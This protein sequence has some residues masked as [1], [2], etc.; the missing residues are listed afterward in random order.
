MSRLE[1]QAVSF[2]W[3]GR[4]ELLSEVSLFL[5][6]GRIIAILGANGAGK[7]SLLSVL[8]GRLRP[9]RGRVLVEGTPLS[10]LSPREIARRIAFLPQI[11]R[12]PFNYPVLDFVLLGRAPHIPPLSL[13]G[14]EDYRAARSA[15]EEVG[16]AGLGERGAATLSGGEF[17][18]VRIARCLAQEAEI[19]LL[20]EPSVLLDPAHAAS[21]A[22]QLSALAKSGKSV[23]I[24]THDIGLAYSVADT[25]ILLHEGAVLDSGPAER[26]FDLGTLRKAF[27]AEFAQISLP[28]A[29]SP[30][31]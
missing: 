9:N 28:S 5:G 29:Y 10:S 8:A 30:R 20:D 1:A 27:G 15:L 22:R 14:E 23:L 12:L 25:I 18:L 19:L 31:S 26:L 11:E 3:P 24:T 17:Q 2:S 4:G 6:A 16:V 7:T 21:V 13:P